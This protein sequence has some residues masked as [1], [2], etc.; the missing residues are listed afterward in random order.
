MLNDD[1]IK[2]VNQPEEIAQHITSYINKMIANNQLIYIDTS[3]MM[4]S[5]R[6]EHF[7]IRVKPFLV[8]YHKKLILADEVWLE[9]KRHLGS[10]L[11]EKREK[12]SK[13]IQLINDNRS[14][15]DFTDKEYSEEDMD[16]AFADRELLAELTFNKQDF[17]QLLITN[18]INL[19]DDAYNL[20]RQASCQGHLVRVCY[21]NQNGGL[22]NYDSTTSMKSENVE[23][24][25]PQAEP[26]HLAMQQQETQIKSKDGWKIFGA[27][28]CGGLVGYGAG[29]YG[30]TII[31]YI[32]KTITEVF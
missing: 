22:Q 7:I 27:S 3:A 5:Y 15:F 26:A 9:L 4:N 20:N 2:R 10:P 8:S 18:D 12:A 16:R 30:N 28:M 6:F 21:L 14:L 17:T 19:E 23:K 32:E 11:P 1:P 24:N 13:A 29:K 25:E 31:K